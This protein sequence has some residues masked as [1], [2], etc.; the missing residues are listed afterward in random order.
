M[1][2]FIVAMTKSHQADACYVDGDDRRAGE[3][4]PKH[5]LSSPPVPKPLRDGNPA[6]QRQRH[7]RQRGAG[8]QYNHV[9]G[10]VQ[11]ADHVARPWGT[12]KQRHQRCVNIQD[13][14]RKNLEQQAA[15]QHRRSH[16]KQDQGSS[17][18]FPPEKIKALSATRLVEPLDETTAR[19]QY[20]AGWQGG[21]PVVGLLEEKGF[22]ADSK[23]ETYAAITLE[24]DTRRW[25]GVPWYLR[26]GKRLGRRVTELAV[27]FKRAQGQGRIQRIEGLDAIL[28]HYGD[29]IVNVNLAGESETHKTVWRHRYL[30]F[31]KFFS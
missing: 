11:E 5:V 1:D 12:Q 10:S 6:Q 28:E 3:P 24:V 8:R 20:A 23:T 25:A 21:E 22:A 7:V 27:I 4:G 31:A 17:H 13:R 9:A 16:C 2:Q 18:P 14:F 26:T 15:P 30:D 19:G 29:W